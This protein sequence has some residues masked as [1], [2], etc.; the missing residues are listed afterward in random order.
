ML[1]CAIDSQKTSNEQ[2]IVFSVDLHTKITDYSRWSV[3]TVKKIH[4]VASALTCCRM[5]IESS[6]FEYW[7]CM[8]VSFL[9]LP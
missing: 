9:L 8:L 2:S 4:V 1:S 5:F 7:V 3:S 6:S